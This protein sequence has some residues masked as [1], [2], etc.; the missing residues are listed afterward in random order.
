MFIWLHFGDVIT[1]QLRLNRLA[2]IAHQAAHKSQRRKLQNVSI[3]VWSRFAI[4]LNHYSTLP[5][6]HYATSQ[7][8]HI[9]LF[10]LLSMSSLT[11]VCG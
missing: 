7:C 11:S 8:K 1:S 6:F 2:D 5:V 3:D 9:P 10:S 4:V